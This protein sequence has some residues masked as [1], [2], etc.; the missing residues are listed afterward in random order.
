MRSQR[1]FS[2][3]EVLVAT[4]IMG[5]AVTGLIVG[6]SQSVKNAAR[7]ADYDRAALLARTQ[8]NELLLDVNLPFT[9]EVRGNFDPSQTSGAPAGWRAELGPYD[10]PPNAQPG[11]VVL[12]RIGLEIWWQPESGTRRT[13][14]LEGFRP[15]RIPIP[16]TPQ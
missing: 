2:L 4:L 5:V 3:L 7:L 11:V 16:P 12:Q 15:M 13:L 14:A 8:M 1:G 10:G 6:L 9:G